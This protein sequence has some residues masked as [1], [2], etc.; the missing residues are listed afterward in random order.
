MNHA[1]RQHCRLLRID[2]PRDDGL[3]QQLAPEHD[4]ACALC[5]VLCPV[6]PGTRALEIEHLQ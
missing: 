3:G 4:R 2:L 6:T 1:H 5:E